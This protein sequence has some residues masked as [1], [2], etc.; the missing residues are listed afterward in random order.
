MSTMRRPPAGSRNRSP[1]GQTLVE[2]ALILPIFVLVL[3]GIFDFGR[4]IYGFNTISNASRQ[5]VRVGIVNQNVTVIKAEGVKAAVS[6]GAVPADV[7]VSFKTPDLSGT[8][9]APIDLGCVVEVTVHYHYNA[10]TP[11]IG[12]L[13][14]TI[15][16]KSTTREPVERS[17]VSP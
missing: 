9:A 11:L 14:G 12:N 2:F 1:R 10:A 6:L 5:A 4:A 3:V 17:Y 8:C 7:D 15:D 13:V 16:M